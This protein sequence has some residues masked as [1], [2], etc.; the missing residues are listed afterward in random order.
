MTAAPPRAAAR[1]SSKTVATRSAPSGAVGS[2]RMRT[3]GSAAMA[4]VSSRSW[5]W[6]TV[7]SSR[8]APSDTRRSTRRSC[9]RIHW[10]VGLTPAA[11]SARFSATV[12]SGSTAGCWWTMAR[13][14]PWASAGVMRSYVCSP[15][16]IDPSSGAID[17]EATDIRVDLPAPFSPRTA[18]TSPAASDSDTPLSA[19]TP[20][21]DFHTSRSSRSVREV[22]G[23]GVCGSVS[24]MRCVTVGRRPPRMWVRGGRRG[25]LVVRY[26]PNAALSCAWVR[27]DDRIASP[28]RDETHS[29]GCGLPVSESSN[30]FCGTTVEAGIWPAGRLGDGEVDRR[31][32]HPVLRVDREQ[33]EAELQILGHTR[34]GW[35]P[36]WRSPGSCGRPARTRRTSSP[37]PHRSPS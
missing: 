21:N 24:V 22:G 31:A 27:C 10:A 18:W 8:R 25:V 17:P 14:W 19:V 29:T 23:W 3:R 15:M 30:A 13:P 9:S 12:R 32:D 4:L 28:G 37:A 35:S 36:R 6:A 2:S 7:R 16:T 33:R 20:G 1:T 26:S 11:A 34:A 5:R